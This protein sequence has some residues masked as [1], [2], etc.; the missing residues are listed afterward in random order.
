MDTDAERP[1][2]APTATLIAPLWH[3]LGLLI[4]L[5][6]FVWVTFR[7]E[8][9]RLA[10]SEQHHGNALH[11]LFVIA[12][13]WAMA[14]YIWLGGLIPGATR[15]RDVIG[16][17]WL[18]FKQ[19]LRDIAIAAAF[20]VVFAAVGKLSSF[21]GRAS[22]AG[23]LQFVNPL[24]A[25]EV[26]LWVMMSVTAGFCE[27]LVFR[28]YFQKQ[29]LALTRSAAFAVLAQA[30]LFG[31]CHWYQGVKQVILIS[32]LGALYGILAQWRKSLRPGMIAHAW[33]DVLNVIPTPFR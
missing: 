23:S 7:W 3:T 31:I 29:A 26:T 27:E 32:V 14:L 22:H 1:K 11:Y 24:G 16:G 19:V 18:N 20:W 8:S 30:V 4:I 17:R 15:L 21:V 28:G 10:E 5:L 12:A 2:A 33:A 9:L 6:A 25:I 13:E